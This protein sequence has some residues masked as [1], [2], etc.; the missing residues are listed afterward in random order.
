MLQT[1]WGRTETCKRHMQ[2]PCAA[3]TALESLAMAQVPWSRT[4][5]CSKH[6]Q[7]PQISRE[8]ARE[9]E[10][11][12]TSQS[13]AWATGTPAKG[14]A[15]ISQDLAPAAVRGTAVPIPTLPRDFSM[16]ASKEAIAW[17]L[18]YQHVRCLI[19]CQKTRTK[20]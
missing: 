16:A 5:T 4:E 2:K 8:C 6:M 18:M 10:T 11:A 19:I 1:I 20:N 7:K 12:T 17:S 3:I 13:A 9:S 14:S 15:A